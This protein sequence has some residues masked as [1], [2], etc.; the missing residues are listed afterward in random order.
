MLY[1]EFLSAIPLNVYKKVCN[2]CMV[3]IVLFDIFLIASICI[4]SVFIYFHW[5]LKKDNMSTNFNVGYLNVY[6]TAKQ[7]DIKNRTYYT[8]NDLNIIKNFNSNNLKLDKK[9]VLGNYVYYIGYITKKPQWTVNS[10]K[11]FYLIINRIK[12][13]FEEYQD[14]FDG[15]KEFI[16]KINDYR[17]PTKYDD[18]Y[19]KIKFNTDDNIPLNKIRYLPAITI[20]IRSVTKKKM[21]NIILNFS[22]MIVCMKYKNARI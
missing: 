17:Y 5:Y 22:R 6:M 1:S 2:S 7:I 9:S 21:L 3:Y 8:Y 15:I 14:V 16:K 4:C 10:V 13:H 19:M 11:T 18:N 12:G 20:T